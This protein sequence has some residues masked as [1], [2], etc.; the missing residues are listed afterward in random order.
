MVVQKWI[1]KRIICRLHTIPP[2]VGELFYIWILLLYK[3]AWS[4]QELHTIFGIEYI[5][6]QEAAKVLGLFDDINEAILA[7]E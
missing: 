4:F 7:I 6:Y 5:T 3:S 1:S 2:W